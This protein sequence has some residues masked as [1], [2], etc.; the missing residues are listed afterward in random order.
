MSF[1][2]ADVRSQRTALRRIVEFIQKGSIDPV[3]RRTAQR[4]VSDCDAR[5]D[6]CELQAI[7]D[8]VKHGTD[9]VPA[10]RNG[11]KYVADPQYAD[12]YV[13]AKRSLTECLRGACAGDC[14]DHT[15]LVGALAASIGFSVGAR[16]WGPKSAPRGHYAHVYPIVKIPKR[17]P[18][19]KTYTGHGMD[20]TVEDSTIGWEPPSSPNVLTAWIEEE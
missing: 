19:P 2:V 18:W 4:I 6:L 7:Y 11:F 8:A 15:I 14:D 16:A 3:I 10:L 1:S 20:T 5:D 13:A 9:K 17:G 12:F